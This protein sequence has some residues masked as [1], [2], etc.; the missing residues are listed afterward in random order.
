MSRLGTVLLPASR[1]SQ[2]AAAPTPLQSDSSAV[3]AAAG[4]D[5]LPEIGPT[6]TI[7]RTTSTR[8]LTLIPPSPANSLLPCYNPCVHAL[9]R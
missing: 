9:R 4:R 3:G 6:E 5:D 1:A 2:R 8:T 7:G